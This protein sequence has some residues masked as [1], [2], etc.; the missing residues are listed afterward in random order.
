MKRFATTAG[1]LVAITTGS[2][3]AQFTFDKVADSTTVV[4]GGSLATLDEIA[5]RSA[6]IA[7]GQVAFAAF[8]FSGVDSGVY[9]FDG[10]TI[11]EVVATDDTPPDIP[12]GFNYS[13]T[14]LGSFDRK[15]DRFLAEDGFGGGRSLMDEIKMR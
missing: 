9:L 10:V 11:S 4:P 15:I 5:T 13:D 12:S 6:V 3:H 7:D 14:S 8:E 1:L 2:A